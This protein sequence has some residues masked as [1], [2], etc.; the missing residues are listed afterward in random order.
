MRLKLRLMGL[1][2]IL[3]KL[4][5]NEFFQKASDRVLSVE[6]TL[7]TLRVM[8][9]L[10]DGTSLQGDTSVRES[11]MA[12]VVDKRLREDPNLKILLLAHNNHIQKT[13]LSFS[14][15]LTAVPMGQHLAHPHGYHA[16]G[17]TH[18]GATVPEMQYP[19]P[20]SQLGFS[21]ELTLLMNSKG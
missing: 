10:F 9:T 16:I 2:P 3:T 12:G 15:E 4:H 7:E 17:L 19:S 6:H 20:E 11:F 8:K 18:L 21:V 13:V 5:A 1:A 14:G